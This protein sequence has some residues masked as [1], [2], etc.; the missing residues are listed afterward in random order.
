MPKTVAE[1]YSK[2]SDFVEYAEPNFKIELD[3]PN[4]TPI[5]AID[6]S[7]FRTIRLFRMTRYLKNSGR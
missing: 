5:E 7:E 2:M 6:F 4:S 3:D 1:Q